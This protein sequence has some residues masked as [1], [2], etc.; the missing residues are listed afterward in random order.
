MIKV[1]RLNSCNIL[2]AVVITAAGHGDSTQ[3][4]DGIGKSL[5]WVNVVSPSNQVTVI[6]FRLYYIRG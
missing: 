5:V 6:V 3:M 4:G 1:M 2:P